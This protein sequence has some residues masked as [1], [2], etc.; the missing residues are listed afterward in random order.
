M[1]FNKH[2]FHRYCGFL[3]VLLIIFLI[4]ADFGCKAIALYR[5]F[6]SVVLVL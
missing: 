3:S 6:R 5:E 2:N 1:P 4:S